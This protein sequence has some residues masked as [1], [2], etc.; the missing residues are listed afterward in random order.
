MALEHMRTQ[1]DTIL[2]SVDAFIKSLEMTAIQNDGYISR[3]EARIIKN[4][5][6]ASDKYKK[7][8]VKIRDA[9]PT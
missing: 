2:L 5:K 9:R 8:L 6:A 4:V 3:D 1:I 7:E